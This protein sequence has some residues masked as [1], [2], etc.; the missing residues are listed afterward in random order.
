[1]TTTAPPPLTSIVDLGVAKAVFA[2]LT[3]PRK[4]LP[5]WLFYDEA[6]SALFE[7]I[8][9]LPEYY[10][11]RTERGIFAAD[12]A[13]MIAQASRPLPEVHEQ[14]DGCKLRVIELGAGS[15]DKTRLLLR[16]ALKHQET[17]LYEPVDVSASALE[18][19]RQRLKREIPAVQVT[20]IVADYTQG[21]E[22]DTVAEGERRLVLYIGSSIGNFEPAQ[23][24]G[25][26]Q[27]LRAGLNAG[28]ALLL[29]VD[30]RKDQATLL[31]AYDDPARV[32][33]RFNLNVLA[34]LNRDLDANFD[35]DAFRH[36]AVWNDAESRMEMHLVSGAAQR[37][38]LPRLDLEINFRKGERIHTEN[39]YKYAP[40]QA[41]T[42]LASAGF[43]PEL[44]WTDPRA[45]FVVCLGRAS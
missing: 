6:G 22:L 21:L 8:T 25:L 29:G 42:L 7:E 10:L 31:A 27:G 30:L 9:R 26:L 40:G 15:A 23:A 45:W 11:T 13:A 36:R 19:A 28:D 1:M 17:V 2:G 44:T 32:T 37:V 12:A 3:A 35:L 24:L 14:R 41:E 33:A 20:P 38:N 18:I 5:S 4:Q 43:V 34:R 39:S 16:A